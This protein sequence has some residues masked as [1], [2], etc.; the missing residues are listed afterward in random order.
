[1]QPLPDFNLLLIDDDETSN[2]VFERAMGH[3]LSETGPWTKVCSPRLHVAHDG[4]EGLVR[5]RAQTPP[6]HLVVLD[7]N[8]PRMSGYDVL[9]EIR[10]DREL[11]GLPVVVQTTSAADRDVR[12]CYEHGASA[13]STKSSSYAVFREQLR[14]MLAFWCWVA[15]PSRKSAGVPT[16]EH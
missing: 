13:F 12:W 3:V 15:E 8:M 10:K 14:A 6:I 4:D 11:C 5:L 9:L 2:M 7:L 1:M 16:P